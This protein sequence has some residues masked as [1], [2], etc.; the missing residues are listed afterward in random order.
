[1]KLY[2]GGYGQVTIEFLRMYPGWGP[3]EVLFHE[4]VHAARLLGFDSY[5]ADAKVRERMIHDGYDDEEEYFAVLVANIY[6]SEK[7][8]PYTS[9]RKGHGLAD[10]HLK[11][12]EV[13]P[14]AFLFED[15]NYEL[16][17][18]FCDQHPKIAPMIADAPAKFNPIRDYYDSKQIKTPHE[19]LTGPFKFQITAQEPAVKARKSEKFKGK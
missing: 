18:A 4:M 14:M 8:K 2:A 11:E 6:I 12:S 9:L 3:D 13:E 7:G 10:P 16:I 5:R 15:Y 17:D 1:M 19:D